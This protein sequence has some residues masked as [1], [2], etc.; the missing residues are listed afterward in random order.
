MRMQGLAEAKC[1]ALEWCLQAFLEA[2]C[3]HPGEKRVELGKALKGR[4]VRTLPAVFL[5]G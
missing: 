1:L 3:M 4:G 2:V 5:R